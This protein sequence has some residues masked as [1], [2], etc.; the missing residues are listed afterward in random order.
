MPPFKIDGLALLFDSFL[1]KNKYG[2]VSLF[3][4]SHWDRSRGASSPL[5]NPP[6]VRGHFGD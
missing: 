4:F 2:R 6:I 5:E 3:Q 1:E